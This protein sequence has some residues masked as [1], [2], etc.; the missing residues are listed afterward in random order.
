[1]IEGVSEEKIVYFQASILA[2]GRK[3]FADFPWRKSQNKWHSLVAEIMLQRTKAE[4][5]VPA[6][7]TFTSSYQ[8]PLDYFEDEDG[9]AFKTLG[10]HWRE[11]LLKELSRIL[12]EKDIPEDKDSLLE[13][14]G[15][16]QYIAAAYRSLHL[17]Y[18]DVII[19]SNVVRVYGR[20]FGFETHAETRRKR[21]FIELS[22]KMTPQE[23]FKE[24]NYGLIDFTREV[25][26]PR[27]ECKICPLNSR[28]AFGQQV[29]S[30]QVE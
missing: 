11:T 23:T 2:W 5:V 3:N 20:Y 1:M 16:G 6:Y 24:Y 10:L 19:D 8:T 13:L 12:S 25:C 30:N 26:K 7:L 15:V 21:W 17:E 29:L 9:M 14:P 18:R 22:E 27:P 4:Q 28:C